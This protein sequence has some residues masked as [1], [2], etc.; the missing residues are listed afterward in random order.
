MKV[1]QAEYIISAVEE[2]FYP[3]KTYPQILLMGRSNV[4]KSSFINSVVNRKQLAFTSSKPGKTQTLNFYS[5][6]NSFMFVDSPGYGYSVSSKEQRVKFGLLI[7]KYLKADVNLKYIF[8]VL[9]LRHKPTEDDML[10]Y[11]FLQQ[12]NIPIIIIATKA[13]KLGSNDLRKQIKLFNDLFKENQIIPFSTI[14]KLGIE[15]VHK[16]LDSIIG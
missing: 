13:D 2:K 14:S 6:N 1:N 15:E 11:D 10:V 12:F 16:I 8:Q 7:E 4:G 5:I 9:D 3:N